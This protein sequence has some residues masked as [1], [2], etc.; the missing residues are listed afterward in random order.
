M[1]VNSTPF[2]FFFKACHSLISKNNV[3]N[4]KF[5]ASSSSQGPG[6]P[7]LNNFDV[8]CAETVNTEQFLKVDLGKY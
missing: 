5:T 3:N 8:W 6:H 2:F 4:V 1:P 7:L